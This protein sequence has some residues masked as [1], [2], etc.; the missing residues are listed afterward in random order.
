MSAHP[1]PTI[2]DRILAD[3]QEEVAEARLLRSEADLRGMIAD[4]SPVRSLPEAL[5]KDFGLIAEFL[6][7]GETNRYWKAAHKE[8]KVRG[9][10]RSH[11]SLQR[12]C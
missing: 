1:L 8:A 5:E 3:V 10:F 4:A 7:V 11:G 12:F 9:S 2:L 6:R